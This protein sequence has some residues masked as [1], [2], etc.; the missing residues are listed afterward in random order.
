MPA[1]QQQLLLHFHLVYGKGAC[2]ARVLEFPYDDHLI[3]EGGQNIRDK[4]AYLSLAQYT[5]L[6]HS[7]SSI[8]ATKPKIKNPGYL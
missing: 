8:V 1:Q 5:D 6:F 2:F 3:Y 7:I 4:K